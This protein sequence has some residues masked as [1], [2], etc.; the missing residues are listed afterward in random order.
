M[1]FVRRFFCFFAVSSVILRV[2]SYASSGYADTDE[3]MEHDRKGWLQT[4][5]PTH[6][7]R[8]QL[9]YIKAFHLS[10]KLNSK[11]VIPLGEI[12]KVRL[13]EISS[14]VYSNL[15]TDRY[16]QS[17]FLNCVECTIK[18]SECDF[19]NHYLFDAIEYCLW[20]GDPI[21]DLQYTRLFFA[22]SSCQY[23][24]GE[25]S[26]NPFQHEGFEFHKYL[27]DV[28]QR[29]NTQSRSTGED[30]KKVEILSTIIIGYN[31]MKGTEYEKIRKEFLSKG[32]PFPA[33][34][35]INSLSFLFKTYNESYRKK[36]F[37][38]LIPHD[39][40]VNQ[41][42]LYVSILNDLICSSESSTTNIDSLFDPIFF[43]PTPLL[44]QQQKL[45]LGIRPPNGRGLRGKASGFEIK[46]NA[47]I[48]RLSNSHTVIS[49]YV[50]PQLGCE[51]DFF[52]VNK[53]TKQAIIVECDG[54]YH[55]KQNIHGS[56]IH[57]EINGSSWLRTNIFRKFGKVLRISGA[58]NKADYNR[59]INNVL[60]SIIHLENS[61]EDVFWDGDGY[62]F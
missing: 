12:S 34:T 40:N 47:E 58:C 32:I 38:K 21:S 53:K 13:K 17:D 9:E 51:L 33:D 39:H 59:H 57:T 61:E 7:A 54:Y 15:V 22:M 62:N 48:Q 6:S 2:D 30:K 28:I 14:W 11:L 18:L 16:N 19:S 31:M 41:V 46:V 56:E 49:N 23:A 37:L 44:K 5:V 52:L 24:P 8:D 43:M 20:T 10:Y 1:N 3:L 42:N 55:F 4:A 60:S 25:K 27:G 35:A 45:M 36:K 26:T 29:Q 50:H